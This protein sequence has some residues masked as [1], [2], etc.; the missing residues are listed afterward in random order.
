MNA[1]PAVVSV[2]AVDA[3]G[4][5][6]IVVDAQVCS[7]LNG[8]LLPVVTAILL[9][10][11]QRGGS[12]VAVDAALVEQQLEAALAACPTAAVRVGI[13]SGRSQAKGIAAVLRRASRG[14]ILVV[15]TVRAGEIETLDAET[16]DAVRD[17]LY[18]LATVVVVRSASAESLTGVRADGLDGMRRVAESVRARGASAVVVAGA[19]AEGRADDLLDE[20]GNVTLLGTSRISRP[21][22]PG[23]GGAHGAALAVALA[24]GETL[25]RATEQAQRYVSLRL[26]RGR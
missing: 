11:G 14:R 24:R 23:I 10:P 7:D 2:H 19:L 21:R 1:S 3:G 4:D 16:L 17:E 12:M 20:A 8:R 26:R 15:P 22:V 25:R 5:D 13:L 9:R 6:G 18:P